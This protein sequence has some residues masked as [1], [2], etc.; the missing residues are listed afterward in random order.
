MSRRAA[1]VAVFASLGLLAGACAKRVVPVVPE[2]EDYVFPATTPGEVSAEQAGALHAAW[3][4]VLAG[5]VPAATRSYEK[6]LKGRP[7]LVP[8]ETGLAYA[9]LRSG[10]LDEALAAFVAVLEDRPE[11]V[12]ALVGAGSASFRRG[13]VDGALDFYRRAQA[14][15]PDDPL[16][17]KRVA[18][19]KLQV[20]ERRMGLAQAALD[21]GDAA[22]AESEYTAALEAAP[23]VAP[24]RLALADLLVARGD[25]AGAVAVL[26]A[27]PS[28]DRQVALRRAGL[29][30]EMNEYA[31]AAEAYRALLARDPG[32]EA[33]RAG[34][35]AAREA[36]DLAQMPEE[37]R[38]IPEAARVTRAD[39]A[40]LVAVRVRALRRA[41]PGEAR[42]AVDIGELGPGAR[43]ARPGARD[44]GRLPEPHVPARRDGAA[45][46]PRPG[47]GAHPRPAG[48]ASRRGPRP[49]RHV[50]LPP[51]LRRGGARPG[52][53]ADG[54]RAVRRVRAVAARVGAGGGVRRRRPRAARRAVTLPR[55]C[56]T[57]AA[58]G[59][60]MDEREL[61]RTVPLFSELS[62]ADITSLGRLASRRRYPK[63]T[64][65]FFENEEGD[66]FFMIVEGRIKVTILGDDGREIILSML[67]PGD[68]FGEMALLDN[69]PRSA[70]AIAVEESELL[71]LHRTD[72]QGVIGDN[73]AISAAL[74]KVLSTRLRRAN[75]QISTL[76][77]LDVYGRVARVILDMAR[78]EGR[79][80]KDGRI[81]FRRATHQEIANRIGT[82]RETVTRMLK[83]LER[84]G[85]VKIE[86]RE[87]VLQ[88]GFE[89]AFD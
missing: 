30:L 6:V 87:L 67:S 8:A 22:A 75:H 46:G 23:E 57:I 88:P 64:V 48:L 66:F 56:G 77:L 82:T 70:T 76:A 83:D 71:S 28:T 18:A 51:R 14:R 52:R 3:S 80:L 42:V 43:R 65:V 25:R 35:K 37:Y 36:Q 27:D 12:P 53:R 9:R 38:A 16:V 17:R 24:V 89:K 2:G 45:R 1:L 61:L 31:R 5:D 50:A 29:L 21:R 33:A 54:P 63:D 20:T 32:D 69:E 40:A 58:G 26:E 74:I 39:L 47:R 7:R 13:D 73:P 59:A 79:R 4:E 34:E 86:G 68:F 81:A 49:R 55:N 41:G 44:H 62:D 19:L 10:R 11:Y 78:E 15:A 72:F 85:L 84:Q 60:D